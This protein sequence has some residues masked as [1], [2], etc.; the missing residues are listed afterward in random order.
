MSYRNNYY[1]NSSEARQYNR[2]YN[3]EREE[4]ESRKPHALPSKKKAVQF[5]SAHGI[6]VIAAVIVVAIF[7]INFVS[8]QSEVTS[9]REEKGQL[10]SKYED[11]KLSNDLYYENMLGAIDLKEIERI[12]VEELGM[13]MA[14]KGQ[15]VTY[16]DEL[17]DYVKQYT[18]IPSK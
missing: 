5:T 1:T 3:S 4:Q 18:D 15:I 11:L 8:L 9:L 13:K 6:T 17:D 2:G 16:T 14:G 10:L 12:A 7:A